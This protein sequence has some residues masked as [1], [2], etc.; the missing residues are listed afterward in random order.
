VKRLVLNTDGACRGN[1]G[2]SSIGVVMRDA[3]NKV[4]ETIA[5]PIG[6]RTN[7]YAEYE[8]IRVAFERARELGA[9][10]IVLR[11]DSQLA[12]RQLEGQYRVK[13]ENIRPLYEAVKKLERSFTSVRYEHVPRELNREADELANLALD[14][15]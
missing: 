13:N 15:G 4:V 12:I 14:R 10:A 5:R 6:V 1:P 8:A 3:S 7:N 9:E 11:A 2:P